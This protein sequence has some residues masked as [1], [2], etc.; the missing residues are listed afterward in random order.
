MKDL[1]KQGALKADGSTLNKD[2]DWVA[3]QERHNTFEYRFAGS[4]GSRERNAGGI[5]NKAFFIE[6][7]R[8]RRF[9]QKR[10]SWK[11]AAGS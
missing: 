3:G 6:I 4:A 8:H 5:I 7:G 11:I 2:S 1:W 10:N 9:I